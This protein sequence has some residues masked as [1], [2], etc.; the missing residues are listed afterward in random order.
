MRYEITEDDNDVEIRLQQTGEHTPQLLA[1]LE[2]CQQGRCG[3]PTEQY[4]RLEDMSINTSVDELT[5]RLH[6]HDGQRL[7]TGELR[8][9]LDYTVTQ[10]QRDTD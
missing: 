2:D 7:D 8:A 5:I 4:E 6:P 3:C 1:A 9:C 10:A